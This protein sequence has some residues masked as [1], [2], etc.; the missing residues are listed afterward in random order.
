LI[1]ASTT[2]LYLVSLDVIR[3]EFYLAIKTSYIKCISETVGAGLSRD[4]IE[5]PQ[6][7]RG[8]NPLLQ[9]LIVMTE[10]QIRKEPIELLKL[11]KFAGA[12]GTGGEAKIVISEGMVKVN[13]EVET[14]KRKQIV[15][16]DEVEYQGETFKVSLT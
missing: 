6:S 4:Q 16:G 12:V 5:Q 13:G 8:I 7:N 10:I 9:F 3:L 15:S 1:S 2:L 11:L 14:R